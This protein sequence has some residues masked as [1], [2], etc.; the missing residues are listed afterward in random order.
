MTEAKVRNDA[1]G[2]VELTVLRASL[3][4]RQ[5]A[6]GL[7]SLLTAPKSRQYN[8]INASIK[9]PPRWMAQQICICGAPAQQIVKRQVT[10]KNRS[11]KGSKD[12]KHTPTHPYAAYS[13]CLRRHY[14]DDMAAFSFLCSILR[15]LCRLQWTP[16]FF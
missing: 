3:Q 4:R 9:Y 1:S 16:S 13:T 5:T 12:T 6:A 2:Q 8:S 15:F 7:A 14:V 11:A 10:S